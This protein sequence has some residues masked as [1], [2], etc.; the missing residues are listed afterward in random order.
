MQEER[1]EAH[2]KTLSLMREKL[3]NE[4]SRLEKE[5]EAT[6]ELRETLLEE[7]AK[8]RQLQA[9]KVDEEEAQEPVTNIFGE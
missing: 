2:Q 7:A 6:H 3:E 4:R 5:R 1:E 8:E 9:R